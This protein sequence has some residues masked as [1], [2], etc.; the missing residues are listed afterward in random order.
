MAMMQTIIINDSRAMRQFLEDIVKSY[1]DCE[2]MGSY[3]DAAI[4]LDD[5]KTKRPDVILLDLEMP[6]MDGLTFLENLKNEKHPIIVVSSY[7]S[8]G[9][10]IVNDAMALGA[11]DSLKPPSSNSKKD[12]KDF[13]RLLHHK[14]AKASLKSQRYTLG[15]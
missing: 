11:I 2:I 10:E 15:N 9:S 14:L 13:K 6:K 1:D 4:A 12:F 7:A 8:D 5:L 3:F